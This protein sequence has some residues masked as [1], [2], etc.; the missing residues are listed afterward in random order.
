MKKTLTITIDYLEFEPRQQVATP[1]FS[2]WGAGG[3]GAVW[4]DPV[5]DWVYRHL[6]KAA[7]RMV[8]LVRDHPAATGLVARALTQAG[9]E[10]L[11]AQSSD[12]AFIMKMGT[13][14]P[15]A[16]RRTKEH[17]G[18]FTRLHDEIR[19][20]RIDE[21]YLAHVESRHNLFPELDYRA[22]APISS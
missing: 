10:L 3:Y 2:S 5:N 9:R 1:P 21:R 8:A 19:A 18:H 12:W 15:Y 16:E 22:W 4:L 13:M 17:V 20:G 7:E 6:H 14:V 11:L